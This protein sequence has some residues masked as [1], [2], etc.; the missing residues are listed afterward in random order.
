M[1]D[2]KNSPR[3]SAARSTADI[4]RSLVAVGEMLQV[5][6]LTLAERAAVKLRADTGTAEFRISAATMDDLHVILGL[7]EE[8]KGWLRT[9]GTDQWS[10][11][12]PDKSGKNRSD[13]VA[14]S[15]AE[16]TTWIVWFVDRNEKIPAAT[17]TVEKNAS[18]AVWP[19]LTADDE[20]AVYLSRLVTARKFSGMG[21]GAA[22]LDWSCTY[23]ARKHRAKLIRIDV[24]TDNYPLHDYYKERG[25]RSAGSCPDVNYPSRARFEKF[26][27]DTDGSGSELSEV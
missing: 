3:P 16:G 5:Q 4:V 21:I 2:Q 15:L 17:V 7:V 13:R 14:A 11:D 10:T 26:T 24:W 22:L 9:K 1:L 25:F 27:S 23:A 12:W 20:K 6:R 19:D 18:P 8:A